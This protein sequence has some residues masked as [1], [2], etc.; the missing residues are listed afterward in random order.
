MGTISLPGS[1]G[2]G[3]VEK[4]ALCLRNEGRET[5]GEKGGASGARQERENGNRS[6]RTGG[7]P[8]AR[9]RGTGRGPVTPRPGPVPLR[10]GPHI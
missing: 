7:A 8:A 2:G 3:V 9:R 4:A 10:C 6:R 5:E 1:Q